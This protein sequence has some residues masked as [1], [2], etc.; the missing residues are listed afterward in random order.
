M[1]ALN[2][3]DLAKLELHFL[4]FPFMSVSKLELATRDVSIRFVRQKGVFPCGRSLQTT[5]TH[6]HSC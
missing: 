6:I 1:V 2:C 3:A 4:E 5:C